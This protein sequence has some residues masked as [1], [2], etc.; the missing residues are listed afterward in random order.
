M[1]DER[2]SSYPDS[3]TDP[4]TKAN[5]CFNAWPI[6]AAKAWRDKERGPRSPRPGTSSVSAG[7]AKTLLGDAEAQF[8]FLGFRSWCTQGHRDVIGD[9]IARDR[10]N[11]RMTN[12]AFTEYRDISRATTDVDQH[13]AEFFSSLVKTASADAIGCKIRS[14]TSKPQRRTHFTMFCTADTA[15][16]TICTF[17]SKRIPLIPIGSRTSSY[18]ST[19]N[20]CGKVCSNC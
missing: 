10:N 17:T 11:C 6:T 5:N 9:L 14:D 1:P 19:M 4:W 20:S 16:V 8:D 18:L 15:P 13:H 7:S 12:R 3:R 2:T